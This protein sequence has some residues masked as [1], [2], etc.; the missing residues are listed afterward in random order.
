MT[1]SVNKLFKKVL[2]QTFIR[3]VN[4]LRSR[5]D[6]PELII[7]KMQQISHHYQDIS[8][9]L[10]QIDG[11]FHSNVELNQWVEAAEMS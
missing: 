1:K 9:M 6:F 4:S 3:Q 11:N 8:N 2:A 7:E 10:T 5:F